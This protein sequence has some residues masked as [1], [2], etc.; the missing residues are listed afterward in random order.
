MNCIVDALS[1][2]LI[3]VHLGDCLKDKR[4]LLCAVLRSGLTLDSVRL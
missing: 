3:L 4:S 1:V 2:Y